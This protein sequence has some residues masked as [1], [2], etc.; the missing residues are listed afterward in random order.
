MKYKDAINT[1]SQFF[2][3]SGDDFPE[4]NNPSFAVVDL[5]LGTTWRSWEVIFL[6]ENLL[7]KDYY[8]AAGEF[9]NFDPTVVQGAVI[10]GTPEQ[11]R[12]FNGSV[13]YNF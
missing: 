4:W 2:D 11:C 8:I 3:V 6:V 13:E 5:S 10:V 7:D 1:R 9:P 12:R